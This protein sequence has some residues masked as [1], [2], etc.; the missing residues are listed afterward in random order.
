MN[1][2]FEVLSSDIRG[3]TTIAGLKSWG[4]KFRV[5]IL[6]LPKEDQEILRLAYRKRVK[7]LE[8]KA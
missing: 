3:I 7:E 1:A 8:D 2:S 4:Q 5:D 6:A